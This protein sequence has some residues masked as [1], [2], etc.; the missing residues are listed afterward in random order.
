M[1]CLHAVTDDAERPL[2]DEDESGMRLCTY[3]CRIFESRPEDERHPAYETTLEFVQKASE[4][5]QWSIDKQEFD[6]MIATKKQS[7]PGLMV[8]CTV[9]TDARGLGFRFWFNAYKSVVEGG[10]VPTHFAASRTAFIPKSSTVD[11]N[12]LR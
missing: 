10:S 11:D 5:I 2:D 3:W 6:E 12:G 8:S 7:A 9:F 1:L 4:D